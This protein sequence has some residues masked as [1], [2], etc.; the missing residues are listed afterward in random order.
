MA[1]P[2]SV[3]FVNAGCVLISAVAQLL[4]GHHRSAPRTQTRSYFA[5]SRAGWLDA[6]YSVSQHV[7]FQCHNAGFDWFFVFHGRFGLGAQRIVSRVALAFGPDEKAAVQAR[8]QTGPLTRY[9]PRAPD[10]FAFIEALVK[11]VVF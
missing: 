1:S 2:A 5:G 4:E 11:N 7:S 9:L 6:S 8:P 10:A 3:A